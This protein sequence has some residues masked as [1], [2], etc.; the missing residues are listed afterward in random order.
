MDTPSLLAA[1]AL[2]LAALGCRDDTTAPTEAGTATPVAIPEAALTSNTWITRANMPADR[3]G[4]SLAVVKNAS[5]Q[6][7]VYVMGGVTLPSSGGFNTATRLVQ[8]YNTAT[9]TWTTKARL[10]RA[11]TYTMAGVING[12]VYLTGGLDS[13]GRESGSL[14]VYNPTTNSWIR[15]RNMPLVCSYGMAGVLN[16]KFYV[17]GQTDFWNDLSF[18]CA[19]SYNPVTDQWTTLGPVSAPGRMMGG[20]IGGKF[21]FFWGRNTFVA[22]DPVTNQWTQR[23]PLLWYRREA[24]SAVLGGRLYIIG[25]WQQ[26]PE[27]QTEVL[28]TTV[29][30]YNPATNSWTIKAPLPS[31]HPWF[32][33]ATVIVSGQSRIDVVGGAR[34]GNN[35]QYVP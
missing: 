34:P 35:L 27:P 26:K 19:F 4:V 25:G 16:G 13:L 18:L 31:V 3:G 11:L 8:A 32:T 15:K 10:P 33:G 6:S 28:T 2:L 14:Y 21:Y 20:L 7:V 29:S 5:G 9:N 22:W 23:R 1:S 12:K 17:I 30:V 24:A